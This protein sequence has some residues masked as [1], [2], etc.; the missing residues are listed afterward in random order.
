MTTEVFYH[1]TIY[2]NHERMTIKDVMNIEI[3]EFN[4]GRHLVVQTRDSHHYWSICL[5][6][7]VKSYV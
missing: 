1:H 6:E 7:Y 5:V 2:G 3:K 4:D